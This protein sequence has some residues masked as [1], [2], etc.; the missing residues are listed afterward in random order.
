MKKIKY[1]L[2]MLIL[3]IYMVPNVN[4]LD[5]V[6]PS[7]FGGKQTGEVFNLTSG[8]R[9]KGAFYYSRPTNTGVGDYIDVSYCSTGDVRIYTLDH[10]EIQRD[11]IHLDT[12]MW[13]TTGTL[14]GTIKHA[15]F[16]IH[17]WTYTE[18]SGYVYLDLSTDTYWFNQSYGS[19]VSVM[20]YGIA[21]IS[22]LD[23]SLAILAYLKS[24]QN[25]TDYSTTLNQ[26]QENIGQYNEEIE[27][28]QDKINDT[29]VKLDEL[30]DTLN[31]SDVNNSINDGVSF[32]DNF[33]TTD[34]GGLSGIITAP[35][36]A[37]N[38]MLN[39]SC[40]PMTATFKGKELSLPCGYEFWAKMGPIQDFINLVLGGLLCYRIIIKLYKLIEK[41]KNPED[42]RVEVMNL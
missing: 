6:L 34:H 26:I 29:N 10:I 15:Y 35:L 13:C 4:A 32:F 38:Q 30:N 5:Y 24:Q 7:K 42:D 11:P 39:T 8:E 40:N 27:I 2:F 12:G 17:Q 25:N 36:I 19:T 18:D 41:L 22:E 33:D 16:M 23:M 1:L 37:I 14:H 31:N 21:N 3:M 28:V 20:F 9:F